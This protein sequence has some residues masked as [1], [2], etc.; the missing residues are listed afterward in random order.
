MKRQGGFTL[1]EMIVVIVI[2]GIL[3]VTAAPKYLD[4]KD[5]AKTGALEGLKGAVI[6]AA[7]MAHGQFLMVGEKTGDGAVTFHNEYPDGLA[8]GIMAVVD[9]EPDF[10]ATAGADEAKAV[11]FNF[12]GSNAGTQCVIY[13]PAANSGDKPLIEIT[14]CV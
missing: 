1:I 6:S 2:L 7:N 10:T 13:T 9:Y 4:F 5:D 12:A 11:K 14:D 3:A 8:T